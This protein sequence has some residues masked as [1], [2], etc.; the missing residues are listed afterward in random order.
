MIQE[1]GERVRSLDINNIVDEAINETKEFL[2]HLIRSQLLT[3]ERKDGSPIGIYSP[4]SDEYVQEKFQLGL[5]LGNSFPKYDLFFEGTLH[6]S[7]IIAVNSSDI[8]IIIT[9]PKIDKVEKLT[10]DLSNALELNE[11]FMDLYRENLL[12]IIQNKIH[13]SLGI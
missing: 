12:P 7:I 2:L 3:G 13:G 11:K 5:F 6:R 9:D 10:G 8:E 4:N 1:F